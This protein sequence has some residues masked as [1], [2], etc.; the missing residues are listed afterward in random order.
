MRP[1]KVDVQL[2]FNSPTSASPPDGPV[3]PARRDRKWR[4]CWRPR[5]NPRHRC[6]WSTWR[7]AA[8][9]SSAAATRPRSRPANLLKD[10]L[11]V[12]VLIE[13][14][15]AI[16]PPRRTD[17]P[18]A[19]GKVRNARG[20]VG[21]FE[22][23][24]DDFAQAAPSSRR[25]LVFGPSRNDARSSC[26]IILDL[27][28]GP[29]FFPAADLRDGYLRADP[30]NPA[31][32]LQAVLRARDLVGTFE[33]PRYITYDAALCAHSRSQRT[34]CTRCLDL[35]PHGGHHAGR[36]PRRDRCEHLRRLRPMRGRLPDRRGLLCAAAGGRADAQAARDADWPTARRA[37]NRPIV[38]VHDDA[39][40]R[41]ADRRAGPV[42]RRTA[43]A[44]AAVRGQRDHADRAGKH[45]CRLR[46]WRI[47]DALPASGAAAS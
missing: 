14:P 2:R 13:P 46:L 41:A 37:A 10:H 42:R 12:T 44:C 20:H 22:V 36:R 34:G 45:R 7:A 9:S 39:S 40:R 5:P 31:A 4:R 16:A 33:K 23:T 17:F 26:D 38:L 18:V 21:A 27:T 28:G 24:V 15:A 8:S 6:R 30:G 35:C 11:D 1:Q 29:A 43:G 3:K 32:M 47:R 25:A 19:K